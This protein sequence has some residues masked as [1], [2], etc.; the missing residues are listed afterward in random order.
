MFVYKLL[1]EGTV[2]ERILKLQAR[3]QALAQ[4]IYGRK[5]KAA[6]ALTAEDLQV[7]LAPLG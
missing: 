6:P 3:K 2:E 7:L 5:G 1:T 4:G